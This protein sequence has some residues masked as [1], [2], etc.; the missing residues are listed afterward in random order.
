M[1]AEEAVSRYGMME[2]SKDLLQK[3]VE[4]GRLKIADY[5]SL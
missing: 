2:T 3:E 5:D 4:N 1:V